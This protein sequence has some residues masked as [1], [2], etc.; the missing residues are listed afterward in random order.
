MD[1]GFCEDGNGEATY[2]DGMEDDGG[3][4]KVAE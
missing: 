4:V 3:V 1:R 2:S